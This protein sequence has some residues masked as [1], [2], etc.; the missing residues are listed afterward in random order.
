M[1]VCKLMG[2]LGN[3]LFQYA[4]ALQLAHRLQDDLCMDISFYQG[5]IPTIY[6]YSI[7][8]KDV[9]DNVMADDYAKAVRAERLYH[10]IQ[11]PIRM[12]RHERIGKWLFEK[13]AQKGY[14]FNY[15]PF[16]Y[17]SPDCKKQNR[18]TYG[19]FQ[20]EQYFDEVT[21]EIRKQFVLSQPIS[22]KACEYL[23]K[24]NESQAIA[25]HIRMG[26]YTEKKNQYLNVCTDQYY[27][28][29]IAYMKDQFP[30]AQ[31]FVFTNDIE[32]VKN[33]D[34]ADDHF[35]Y[36]EG[37]T[38]VEDLYLMSACK[39]FIISGSTFSWW[40]SYLSENA[41]KVTAAPHRWMTTLKEEPAIYRQDM[42]RIKA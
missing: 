33:K 23:K 37:L 28:N 12:I 4:Y 13:L 42:V 14:Y 6:K 34:Y 3:Q 40:G 38:D 5:K 35:V 22:E 16:F 19:Y 8:N 32:T 39:N 36:V 11:K 29:A 2:G 1:V 21:D 26:D 9:V 7:T 30:N 17:E 24:I 20:G 10:L 18:Y 25:I 27:T 15:D 41:D 31:F